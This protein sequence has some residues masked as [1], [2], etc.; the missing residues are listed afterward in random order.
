MLYFPFITKTHYKLL[1]F[2]RLQ[3]YF[4]FQTPLWKKYKEI[5]VTQFIF[6]YNKLINFLIIL[7]E[8]KNN[9]QIFNDFQGI[10]YMYFLTMFTNKI[11]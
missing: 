6:F 1:D 9:I 3:E 7:V 4:V 8:F 5:N 2:K 11:K 10:I